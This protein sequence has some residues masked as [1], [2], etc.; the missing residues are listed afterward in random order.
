M[1]VPTY[2]MSLIEIRLFPRAYTEHNT[3]LAVVF[4]KV[5]MPV[6]TTVSLSTERSWDNRSALLHI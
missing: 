5:K 3:S 4:D 1:I 6:Q 2:F